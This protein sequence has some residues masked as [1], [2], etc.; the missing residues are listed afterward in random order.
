MKDNCYRIRRCIH[1]KSNDNDDIDLLRDLRIKSQDIDYNTL[2]EIR[3]DTTYLYIG[4]SPYIVNI[5]Y[6]YHYILHIKHLIHLPLV[7]NQCLYLQ[8]I[9]GDKHNHYYQKRGH[10]DKRVQIEIFVRVG[11]GHG[12]YC[13]LYILRYV[14]DRLVGQSFAR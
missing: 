6:L 11:G 13:I 3:Q 10:R 12:E 4:Y 1:N 5:A 7:H 2:G 9:L 14:E 8:K